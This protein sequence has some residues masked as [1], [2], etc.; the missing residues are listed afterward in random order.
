MRF[1]FMSFSCPDADFAEFVGIAK[2][3]GY[4]G[5]EP[6]TDSGHKHGIETGAAAASLSEA[7][8]IAADSGVAICC[9]ATG[10]LYADPK[11]LDIN[12]DKTKAA[13][14]LAAS[15]GAPVIRVF[16]GT[17]PEGLP[18][19]AAF[20][21]V[22]KGLSAVAATAAAYN[23]TVCM[24]THDSW[25]DPTHVLK[26]IESVNHSNIKVNWDIM[27][28]VITAGYAMNDAFNILKGHIRH[29]HVHDGVRDDG[30]LV[31]K[32]IGAGAVDHRAAV[33]ALRASGYDGFISGEWIGW[34]PHD[35]HLPREIATLKSL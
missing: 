22:V 30:K 31:F 33:Q 20:D 13:I 11:T 29:V 7:K 8:K 18:R 10:C 2:R 23:V 26:V 21:S 1:S 34:E 4:D 28:P 6:R 9:V 15:V 16:G 17:I 5:I 27:H 35:T 14:E 3:Y 25:C 32:P 12:I 19:E 24:E